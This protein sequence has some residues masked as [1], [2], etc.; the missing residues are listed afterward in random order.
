MINFYTTSDDPRKINKQ[1]SLTLSYQTCEFKDSTSIIN[2]VIIVT[3]NSAIMLS[4]YCYISDFDRYYF[5]KNID[6]M[7]GG[8][9]SIS[10]AVDCLKSFAA[11]IALLPVI[12][13]RWSRQR[14]FIDDNNLPMFPVK[15][16]KVIEFSG[17][18]FNIETAT[19]NS[20]NFVLTV[21]GG[22]QSNAS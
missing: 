14:T 18:D 16:V 2:P 4:N 6:V 11:Q 10:L 3:Y 20:Q 8:R 15:T 1:M 9:L 13:K 7:T 5:I 21:A 12:A 22:G 17:G 19:A